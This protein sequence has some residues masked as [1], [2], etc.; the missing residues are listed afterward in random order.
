MSGQLRTLKNRIRSVENTK[1]ITRAMEM[2]AAAKLRRFQ[3]MMVRSR[4]FTEGLE[5]LLRRLTQAKPGKS[6]P[7][8]E[9]RE[10]K[11]VALVLMTSDTGL[12][13]SYN[14]DLIQL[15]QRF[16]ADRRGRAASKPVVIAVGKCGITAL[17][18]SGTTPAASFTDLRA[19]RIEDV[20]KETRTSIENLYLDGRVDAVYGVYSHFKTLT[21]YTPVLEKVLPLEKPESSGPQEEDV[22]Y[23]F[24]PSPETIFEKIVPLFFEAKIRT[25]FLE[26]I[27]SEQIARMRAMHQ[28]TEN[29]REMI[30]SLVLLRNKARQAM[31]TKEIIEIISGSRALKI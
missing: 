20:L 12:C 6:H 5:K 28:A 14:N 30:D 4:P 23:I 16:L 29:A 21:A 22:R 3:D 9:V 19:S 24:E 31:I 18:S 13:G 11:N 15:A 1:K 8:L 2:V 26:A 7:F 27:V 17:K 10:E 25:L